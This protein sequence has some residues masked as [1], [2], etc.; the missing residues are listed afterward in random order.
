MSSK[1]RDRLLTSDLAQRFFAE[2]NKQA[3]NVLADPDRTCKNSVS[4]GHPSVRLVRDLEMLEVAKPSK[5]VTKRAFFRNLVGFQRQKDNV[6][7]LS[8]EDSANTIRPDS[9]QC[10]EQIRRLVSSPLLQGSN[11]LCKLLQYLAQHTLDSPAEHVKE[12][13]IATEVLGRLAGFDPQTDSSVRM[14]VGRLRTKLVEYYSSVGACDPILVDIPKGQYALSFEPRRVTSDPQIASV[15]TTHTEVS[16]PS[17]TIRLF[18]VIASGILAAVAVLCGILAYSY[19]RKA[20]SPVFIQNKVG[21]EFPALQTLWNP[22]FRGQGEPIIVFSNAPFIGNAETGIRLFDPTKDSPNDVTRPYT[23]FGELMG[24]VELDRLFDQFGKQFRLKRGGLFTL[25]DVRNS[26]LIFVGSPEEDITLAEIPATREFIFRRLPSAVNR[27]EWE[28]VN[29]HPR[30]GEAEAY[31][32]VIP[33]AGAETADFAVVALMRGLDPSRRTL[34]LE[35]ITTTGTQAAVNFVC[36]ENSVAALLGKLN[37]T[38]GNGVPSFEALLR[39]KT[40]DAVP[41]ETQLI[42]LRK[43]GN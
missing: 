20:T 16:L 33:K 17:P 35:G 12:Y 2:V 13:Q 22:F 39:V 15:A 5:T 43:T 24:I 18:G 34:I 36:D 25:D 6:T 23:G 38:T 14:Q 1:N 37:T 32:F 19:Y 9:A 29:A 11:A 27:G 30:P 21:R 42:A 31:R 40:V 3:R 41:L 26:N 10:R 7:A 4:V 28:I 8:H